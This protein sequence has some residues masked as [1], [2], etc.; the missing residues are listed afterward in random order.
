MVAGISA[1]QI[2]VMSF[3]WCYNQKRMHN[4]SHWSQDAVIGGAVVLDVSWF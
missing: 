3:W 2:C 1:V 4:C